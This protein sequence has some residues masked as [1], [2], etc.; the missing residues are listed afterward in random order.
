MRLYRIH[1]MLKSAKIS[2]DPIDRIELENIKKEYNQ[3]ESKPTIF[4]G[5]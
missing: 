1:K 3:S 5:S 2:K 4:Q